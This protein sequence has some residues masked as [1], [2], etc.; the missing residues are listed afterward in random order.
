MRFALRTPLLTA[1][2][3]LTAARARDLRQPVWLVGGPGAGAYAVSRAL[4]QDGDPSGFVS[5]RQLLATSREI[6]D[7]LTSAFEANPP[8]DRVSLYVERIERQPPAVQE[9]VLSWVDEGARWQGRLISVRLFGQSDD[10]FRPADL[11]AP[12]RH[13]LS[14]LVIKLPPLSARQSEIPRIALTLADEISESLGLPEPVI[15]DLALSQLAE[16][17]WPGNLEELEAV[18]RRSLVLAAGQPIEEFGQLHPSHPRPPASP[19]LR[20]ST[21]PPR[22]DARRAASPPAAPP[23]DPRALEIVLT[24]LAHELKNPMVTIKTFGD[25][26]EELMADPSLREKFVGLTREAIDRMDRFLEE[27]L[28]FS[29]FA[30]PRLQTVPLRQVLSQAVDANEARIREQVKT[31]GVPPDLRARIDAEQIVFAFKALLRGLARELPSETPILVELAPSGDLVFASTGSGAAQK[32]QAVL[33]HDQDGAGPRS[34]D[35]IM[36]EAL[37]RRNG[38]SSRMVRDRDRLEVRLSFPTLE[39][40]SNG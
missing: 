3:A 34:L 13:R 4:H 22:S 11:L 40:G 21:T 31:N 14:A 23:P 6:E 12:L 10:G 19:H 27:L 1:E 38:G 16:Q 39:R 9:R 25:H 29:R 2:S 15:D 32:L 35:L 28:C 36:A 17:E 5:V 8:L 18:I 30:E 7:R 24:E 33:D 20:H 37:I 26:V